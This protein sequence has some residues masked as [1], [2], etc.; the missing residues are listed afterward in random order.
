MLVLIAFP[1]LTAAAAMLFADRHFDAHVFDPAGGGQPIIWQHLF[2]FFGHPEVYIVVLPYFGVV[3][4]ILPVFSRRPVFGYGGLGA[5]DVRASRSLSVGVWAHHMFAT[6]AVTNAYFSGLSMLIA[7]PTGR[8]VLQLDRH[9]VGRPDHAS[10]T[11][12]LFALGFM[13]T[14]LIGGISGVFLAS[15]PIDLSVHDS[16]FVVAHMHYVLFGG[17]VFALYAAI[18]YWFPK[19]TGRMLDRRLGTIHFWLTFVGFH[20]TF[21]VQHILGADGM[22]RRMASYPLIGNM[23]APQPDLVGRRVPARRV[24]VAVPVERVALVAPRTARRQR[25]V[26]CADPRVGRH[27]AAVAAQLRRAAAAD[28]FEPTGVGRQVPRRDRTEPHRVKRD[29][30]VQWQMFL[31]VAAFIAVIDVVYWFVSYER[32]GTTMLTLA[33]GLAALC[34]GWLFD[35]GPPR[36]RRPTT[37]RRAAGDRPRARDRRARRGRVPARPPVGGRW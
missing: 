22:P 31:G 36:S 26:G 15:A 11:P 7:I 18:Y 21:L 33:A 2:W 25:P 23:A 30:R 16:Y 27:L 20:L 5:G 12:M 13:V 3:T 24:D 8:E 17:S 10:P 4:E 9:D 37:S 29:L 34:G 32:A 35:P 1:V 6:G 19:I 14:F 28:P